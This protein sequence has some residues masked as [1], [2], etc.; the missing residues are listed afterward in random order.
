MGLC[1]LAFC[2]GSLLIGKYALGLGTGRLQ[3][4]STITLIFGGEA[5]LY[6]V[7]ERRHFW[8]SRPSSWM[9]V[10]TAA[11][12]AI[13]AVLSLRGIEMTALSPA[14]AAAVFGA[15]ALF[16]V[17]LDFVKVPLFDRLT[18][19]RAARRRRSPPPQH[20]TEDPPIPISEAEG[21]LRGWCWARSGSGGVHCARCTLSVS[22]M[23]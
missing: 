13:I 22:T 11:D 5:I 2:T 7:R 3:T 8:K 16:G 9:I 21:Y 6:C 12:I 14:I 15:S 19:D 4:L 17:L 1:F 18:I 10:A 20:A 23:Q